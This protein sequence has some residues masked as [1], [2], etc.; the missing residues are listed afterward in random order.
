MAIRTQ[1]ITYSR[2]I[3]RTQNGFYNNFFLAA[4]ANNA[5]IQP[6][7]TYLRGYQ[8]TNRNYVNFGPGTRRLWKP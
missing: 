3:L 1:A 7:T 2:G 6:M 8:F 4:Q 5:I